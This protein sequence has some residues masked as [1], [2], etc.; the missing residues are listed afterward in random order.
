MDT[1]TKSITM[2]DIGHFQRRLER[3]FDGDWWRPEIGTE[4]RFPRR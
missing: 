2:T 4:F 1:R 3:A